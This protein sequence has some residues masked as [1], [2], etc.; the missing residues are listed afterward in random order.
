MTGRLAGKV[1]VITGGGN[2]LGRAT[3][4]RFAE[5]SASI[6]IADLL[7]VPGAESVAA[8]EAAGGRAVF[9]RVDVTSRIDNDA[10][11]AAAVEN[12]GG[13]HVVVTA[14]GISHAGYVSGDLEA[15]VKHYRGRVERSPARAFVELPREEWQEVL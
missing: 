5:E 2:G 10:V 6:V 11:A 12:F 15:E 14:A 9:V 7:E 3:A 8:V 13:L 4:V 1:A